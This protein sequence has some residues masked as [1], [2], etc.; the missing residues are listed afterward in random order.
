MVGKNEVRAVR[1]QIVKGENGHKVKGE[2]IT[3]PK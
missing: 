1:F 2:A 3:A